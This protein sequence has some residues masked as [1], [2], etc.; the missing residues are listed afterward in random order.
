MNE[1]IFLFKFYGNY[2]SYTSNYINI[3]TSHFIHDVNSITLIDSPIPMP[4]KNLKSSNVSNFVL[5]IWLA[6]YL[7][8]LSVT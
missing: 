1:P 4:T 3:K 8:S 7:F 5:F 2:F 6:F